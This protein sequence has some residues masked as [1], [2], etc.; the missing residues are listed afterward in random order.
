MERRADLLVIAGLDG[1]L[2]NDNPAWTATLGWSEADLLGKPSQWLLHPDDR[3]KTGA[4]LDHL[5]KGHK[6]LRFENRRRAKDGS[7]HWIS[8]K[9]APDSGRIYNIGRDITEHKRARGELQQARTALGTP[10]ACKPARRRWQSLA[11]ARNPATDC[12]RVDRCHCL[13]ARARQRSART[14]RRR[15]TR[16][17]QDSQRCGVGRRDHQ[18]HHRVNKKDTTHRE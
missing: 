4:E 9:A 18:A 16:R 14:C 11:R 2:L 7:Y 1:T 17:R 15:A 5:A 3:E 8:W 10:A 12:R 6:T 13:R